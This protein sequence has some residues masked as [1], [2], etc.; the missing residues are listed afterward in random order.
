MQSEAHTRNP[1][2]SAN[3]EVHKKILEG[4]LL[5]SSRLWRRLPQSLKTLPI[6][7]A[8]GRHLHGLVCSLSKREQNFSTFF[9]RNR[10]ELELIC[11]LIWRKP[12]G[13]SVA[14]AVL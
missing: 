11:R 13:A 6:G 14:I 2:P 1:R 8:Y 10:P 12:H 3:L 9:M 4:Y 5:Q 7:R